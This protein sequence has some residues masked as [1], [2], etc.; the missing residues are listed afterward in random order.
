[1]FLGKKLPIHTFTPPVEGN[2]VISVFLFSLR[3]IF[4]YSTWSAGTILSEKQMV[5]SWTWLVDELPSPDPC[6]CAFC[7]PLCIYPPVKGSYGA[8][9][10]MHGLAGAWLLQR[11]TDQ[12]YLSPQD[13]LQ[14]GGA[15]LFFSVFPCEDQLLWCTL[16]TAFKDFV[17]Q[18]VTGI[19][20]VYYLAQYTTIYRCLSYYTDTIA[21]PWLNLQ[22]IVFF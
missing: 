11:I 1:M 5:W 8:I 15:E 14:S 12:S 18:Q 7:V 16:R 2:P 3:C 19:S 20:V 13:S 17:L 10:G 4:S 22:A 21:A 9:I 6:L